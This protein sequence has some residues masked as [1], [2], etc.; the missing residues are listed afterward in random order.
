MPKLDRFSAPARL[1]GPA[2]DVWSKT[3]SGLMAAYVGGE[4]PQFY[5]PTQKDTPAKTPAPMLEWVA[6]PAKLEVETGSALERWRM[7]DRDRRHQDE[8]CEW[9]VVRNKS[10]K[11]VRI[12][13]TTELPEYWEH[14]FHHAPKQLLALYRK[15]V[16][17]RVEL[18]HLRG[19]DGGYDRANRWN[20]SRPGRLAH[21]MQPDN[22]LAAAIDLVA[23]STIPRV[24]DGRSVT[25]QQELV[26]CAR[27]GDPL[28]HS[29]PHIASAVNVAARQG[30]EI[31]LADP[32]GLH[33]GRPITAG[34]VTPDGADAAKFWQ[35]ERGDAEHTLRARFEVPA[36]RRYVVGDIKLRGRPIQ[37]GGQVA[38][39]VRVWIKARVKDAK[40]KPQSRPC[41]N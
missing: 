4:F 23:R 18:A 19:A 41:E 8:Y 33:L 32:P 2:P 35:I 3:V 11:I 12:V 34:M 31:A 10:R 6:F 1:K 38:D 15:L 28:R 17:P 30:K 7:A 39:G 29:D 37:F 13:F 36:N 16:D 5:D 22:K 24:K 26:R 40:H 14:L 27:L 21:L 9:T 20:T 25:G